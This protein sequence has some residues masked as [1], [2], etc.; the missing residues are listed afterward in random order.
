MT[1]LEALELCTTYLGSYV[2]ELVISVSQS[3]WE[4]GLMALRR[5]L[6]PGYKYWSSSAVSTRMFIQEFIWHLVRSYWIPLGYSG[7]ELLCT[8]RAVITGGW[9]WKEHPQNSTWALPSLVPV[10]KTRL[11]I[12]F[13]P[14]SSPGSCFLPLLSLMRPYVQVCVQPS[15]PWARTLSLSKFHP[16]ILVL[17]WPCLCS[18]LC[19]IPS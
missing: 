15:V 12:N 18:Q 1:A 13:S 19:S 10:Y 16:W 7:L 3:S 6:G 5:L 14:A 2:R 4:R 9:S 11:P 17:P 8:W